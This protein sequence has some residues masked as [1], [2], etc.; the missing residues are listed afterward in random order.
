[1]APSALAETAVPVAA[2]AGPLQ[3]AL[4]VEPE[5]GADDAPWHDPSLPIEERMQRAEGRPLQRRLMA[6]MAQ[7]DCGQCGYL[8]ETYAAA[9]ANGAETRLNLCV[10]GEKS[11]L[12]ALKALVE[13]AA[14]PVAPVA[15][16]VKP[17][18][19]PAPCAATETKPRGYSRE[20]PVEVTFLSRRKLN[21]EGSEKAT[22]HIE[23]DLT[24]SSLDYVVG[25]S[26]GVYPQNDAALVDAILATI[27]A[28]E[29]FPI[30]DRSLRQVLLNDVSLGTTPDALFELVSYITGG[31][32]KQKAKRLA[33][34]EDPDGDAATLD[35]LATLEKFSGIHP[36]PEALVECLEPL[37][38]RLYSISS[39]HAKFPGRLSLTVD[40]VRYEIGDRLR[41]G[42]ASSWLATRIEPGARLKAYVQKAHNFALPASGDTPV[43]MI[44]PGT[45]VAPFRAFLQER[46]VHAAKG[47]AWLFFGHQR[48]ATDF[49][50]EEDIAAF[51]N[52]GVL[53]NLS[54]AWS[55]DGVKKTYVQDKLREAGK[56]VW[57]WIARGAH[58]YVCGDALRMAGDVEKALADIVAEHSRRDAEQARQFVRDLKQGG[59]YQTDVY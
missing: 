52:A 40:H 18:P 35:V 32:R 8:C 5:T 11:T 58:I 26:F 3:Q 1:M 9:I 16:P 55:R 53:T 45:G 36:D 38:P 34:G 54:L 20:A 42:A 37:Q 30:M 43:I 28:P 14:S 17:R 49:L 25:D 59:A 56:E 50:Y 21:R 15:S 23:F 2:A 29:D 31:E 48:R 46:E 33:G 6:A 51:L 57:D 12:R 47:G 41:Q 4:H 27:R 24:D 7:Q 10:P 19:A 44:G 39:S 13:A 22:Y